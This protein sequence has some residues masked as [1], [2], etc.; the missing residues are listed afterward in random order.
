MPGSVVAP[1]LI[2][3][4]WNAVAP[5]SLKVKLTPQLSLPGGFLGGQLD[6]GY[7]ITGQHMFG[8]VPGCLDTDLELTLLPDNVLCLFHVDTGN[9]H[10]DVT[11]DIVDAGEGV[12]LCILG[13]DG[14]DLVFKDA[15]YGIRS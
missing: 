2:A 15:F 7:R 10:A 9:F 4:S 14:I 11:R 3:A 8:I 1:Y 12:D 6:A 13:A 5:S